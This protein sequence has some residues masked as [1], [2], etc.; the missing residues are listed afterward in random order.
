MCYSHYPH[1][2]QDQNEIVQIGINK[3]CDES[4]HNMFMQLPWQTLL[5][6]SCSDLLVDSFCE[7]FHRSHLIALS[8]PVWNLCRPPFGSIVFVHSFTICDIAWAILHPH[9]SEDAK[10]HLCV[11]LQHRGPGQCGSSSVHATSDEVAGL[12][13]QPVVTTVADCRVIWYCHWTVC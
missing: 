5:Q 13:C 10:P 12:Y 9:L 2:S 7:C 3:I 6:K 11:D 8:S 1:E 4:C